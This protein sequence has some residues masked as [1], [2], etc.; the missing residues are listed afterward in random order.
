MFS[1][2]YLDIL[3]QRTNLLHWREKKLLSIIYVLLCAK[4]LHFYLIEKLMKVKKKCRNTNSGIKP[5]RWQAGSKIVY[6]NSNIWNSMY[7]QS[8]NLLKRWCF[9]KNPTGLNINIFVNKILS[10]IYFLKYFSP[11][12]SLSLF[13]IV[14]ISFNIY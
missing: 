3:F 6:E 13:P 12:P 10:R 8:G 11:L 9:F 5:F 4:Y 2:A 1:L 14:F 7:I